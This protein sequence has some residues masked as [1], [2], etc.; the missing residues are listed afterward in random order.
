MVVPR[1]LPSLFPCSSAAASGSGPLGP[2]AAQ[3]AARSFISDHLRGSRCSDCGE[4]DDVILEFDHLHSKRA[5]LA[6][7]VRTGASPDRIQ[8]ELANCA[9]VCVNCHR[10]R[11]AKRDR[12]WRLEPFAIDRDPRLTPGERRNMRYVR[13][14]LMR[15]CCADCGDSRLVVLEFDH[16]GPKTANVIELARRGVGLGRLDAEISQCVIRCANCHRRRTRRG[17][18]ECPRQDSNLQP[19][20]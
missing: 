15:S 16:V 14:L 13:E 17:Q 6:D 7:M 9:V 11:T 18:G 2:S 1:L 3:V 20:P 19:S 4:A 12:S 10:I 5:N 8:R